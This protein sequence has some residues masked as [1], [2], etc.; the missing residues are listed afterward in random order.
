MKKFRHWSRT[1]LLVIVALVAALGVGVAGYLS[2]PGAERT[3]TVYFAKAKGLYVGDDVTVLSVP[4][5][6]VTKI[7]P[8]PDRVRVDLTY[9]ADHPIPADAKAVLVAPSVVTVRQVAFSPAYTG[10]PEL[11]D[12]ATIPQSR[13]AIPVEWDE[14]K[15]QVNALA[16]ALGP[17]GA[18]A[19][20]AL[21]RL[22]EA[23]AANLKGQGSS[24][25]ETVRAMSKAMTALSDSKSD[26]FGTVRNLQVFIAAIARSDKE[27]ASF[28]RRLA[29]VSDV[30]ADNRHDLATTVRSTTKALTD[31]QSFLKDN[32]GVLKKSVRD[33]RPIS[34][35]L[36]DSRQQLADLLHLA[37]HTV[38]NFYGIYEPLTGAIT[39]TASAANLQSPGVMV[40]SAIF[41]L[42]GKPEDCQRAIAPLAELL[43]SDPPPIGVS[44]IER[45]GRDNSKPAP[46]G[47]EPSS[48]TSPSDG[49]P[50]LLIPGGSR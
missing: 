29:T 37:P 45:G 31:L 43:T 24:M 11:A 18:N 40:C 23:G 30:F 19:D 46:G 36:A 1:R 17:D 26:L 42:G 10:G 8:E 39:A 14:I 28:N 41:S 48:S 5:G 4:I 44:P 33:L 13:T 15:Q 9:E 16:T 49:L 34:A 3:A 12:G 22:L 47:S 6:K 32:R 27:V 7:T 25:N 20:G 35:M 21:S 38:S 50:G 2:G